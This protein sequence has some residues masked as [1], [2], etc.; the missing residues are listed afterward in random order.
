MSRD[1]SHT[2][3]HTRSS[4]F[5]DLFEE[6]CRPPSAIFPTPSAATP[7]AGP[8]NQAPHS[9]TANHLAAG[10]NGVIGVNDNSNMAQLPGSFLPFEEISLP[11]HLQPLNPEDEDDVVPDMHAAFGINRALGQNQGAATTA[12]VTMS[13]GAGNGGGA[14]GGEGAGG[15][16]GG[17]GAG[18]TS[19]AGAQ[20][21]PV[22]RDFG[23][24]A[25]VAG[26]K[27]GGG[28]GGGGDDEQHGTA[29]RREGRRTNLLLLR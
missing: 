14:G 17:G 16:G 12:A 4:R 28:G 9:G 5:A 1:S 10:P 25:L 2:Y 24:E 3:M 8:S 27:I 13:G 15:G 22:W 26:V 20:R 7:G 23:L 19:N 29:A 6:F 18:E 21:E 11:A